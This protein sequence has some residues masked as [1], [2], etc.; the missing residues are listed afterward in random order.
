M[1]VVSLK[2]FLFALCLA[3]ASASPVFASTFLD[4]TSV[5]GGSTGSFVGKLGGITVNGAITTSTPGF[6]F[7]TPTTPTNSWELST[8][9]NS[10]PQFSYSSVYSPTIAL[11]DRVG[12]TSFIG[13]INPATITITFSAPVTNPI[14]DVANLDAMRVT[15]NNAMSLVL[16]SGNGGGGDGLQVVG[17]V[18]SD[19]NPNTAVGQSPSSAPLLTGPRSAYGSVELKGTFTT[20]TLNVINNG[21]GDGGSF[22]LVTP[23][24]SSFLLLGSGLLACL[25]G[26][27]RK[28]DR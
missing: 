24:P 11:T 26:I 17:N 15:A 21:N 18:I 7:N 20:L 22:T 1:K 9:D 14:F 8:I 23:E 6:V 3:L 16:L 2:V 5:T 10:S 4:L 28:L 25:G 19:A 13:S 12:Y 27:R